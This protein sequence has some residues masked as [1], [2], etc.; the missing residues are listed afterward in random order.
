MCLG[1]P[2][3]VMTILDAET[4]E[5]RVGQG[6]RTCFTGLVGPLE[7]GDWVLMHAGFAIEHITAEDARENLALIRAWIDDTP[8]MARQ[9]RGG[10]D[11]RSA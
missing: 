5:V 7:P 3:E 9:A 11:D 2:S 4:V 1:V 8:A 10:P 6:T